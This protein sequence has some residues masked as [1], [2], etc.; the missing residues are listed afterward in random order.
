M[1][2]GME[3][4]CEAGRGVLVRDC[5]RCVQVSYSSQK[6]I[7][8]PHADSFQFMHNEALQTHSTVHKDQAQYDNQAS[9]H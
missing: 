1:W 7:G 3:W 4:R 2:F 9:K 5:I 6:S 8:S